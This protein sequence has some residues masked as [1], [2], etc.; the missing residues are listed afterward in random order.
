MNAQSASLDALDGLRGVDTLCLLVASDD[1]PLSGLPGFVDWRLCGALSRQ[2]KE[3]FFEGRVGEHLLI[4]GAPRVVPAR[5]FVLGAGPLAEAQGDA[6]LSTA[7]Q[8]LRRAQ[9]ASVAVGF[10]DG[11]G[12]DT[13]RVTKA[14]EGA[15]SGPVVVL[16]P[17]KP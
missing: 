5:I 13:S 6:L 7:A 9:V 17:P 4:P 10:S 14:L 2:L 3:H 15:V 8:V 12:L 16:G 1:R 11:L